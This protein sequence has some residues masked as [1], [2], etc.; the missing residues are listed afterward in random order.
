MDNSISD[1]T[2]VI[3]GRSE[4]VCTGSG[5]TP[6]SNTEYM[7]SSCSCQP[8]ETFTLTATLQLST[9]DRSTAE[10][11]LNSNLPADI[12]SIQVNSLSCG[13]NNKRRKK[14]QILTAEADLT[15]ETKSSVVEDSFTDTVFNIV[16]ALVSIPEVADVSEESVVTDVCNS[17]S[18]NICHEDAT[19]HAISYPGQD[20]FPICICKPR[21]ITANVYEPG[22]NCLHP[23]SNGLLTF[24]KTDACTEISKKYFKNMNSFKF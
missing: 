16:K 17:S 3:F 24:D 7:D 10:T 2:I 9:C 19:C 20:M 15:V 21:F 4:D 5:F 13:N 8:K 12:L 23:C 1:N 18:T 22:L 11:I 14:R 6:C